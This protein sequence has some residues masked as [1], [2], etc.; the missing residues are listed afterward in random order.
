MKTAEKVLEKRFRESSK[1]WV[2]CQTCGWKKETNNRWP[3]AKFSVLFNDLQSYLD[4]LVWF[5][6]LRQS[7]RFGHQRASLHN[8]SQWRINGVTWHATDVMSHKITRDMC[9]LFMCHLARQG[10]AVM[11][12]NPTLFKILQHEIV[13]R[14]IKHGQWIGNIY[15][16]LKIHMKSQGHLI[17]TVLFKKSQ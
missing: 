15:W 7:N 9:V 6:P 10:S 13:M 2:K 16:T 12:Y 14:A 11:Q 3:L 5:P 4:L 1:A 8:Q 17:G